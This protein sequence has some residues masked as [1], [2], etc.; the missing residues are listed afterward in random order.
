[1]NGQSYIGY[2]THGCA[3]IELTENNVD[4]SQYARTQLSVR[5]VNRPWC[6]R[7]SPGRI[8]HSSR[9]IRPSVRPFV[10]VS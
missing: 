7:F 6:M 10:P 5:C 8:I 1:M 2:R 3:S 4:V 9:S